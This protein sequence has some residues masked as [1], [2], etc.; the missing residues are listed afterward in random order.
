M[1]SEFPKTV[2]SLQHIYLPMT[3][4]VCFLIV[5][6][7]A[8]SSCGG[9]ANGDPAG[10]QGSIA[11]NWQFNLSTTG[12]TFSA[13]PLQGGFLL[14]KNGAVTGQIVFSI[15][16]TTGSGS[17]AVTTTCNN[18]TATVTGTM[19]GQT[20]N[21]TAVL[22]TF[23]KDGV[24]ATTQ[25]LTLSGGQ[26]SSDG[27]TIQ[28][29]KY[30]LTP[31][32][33]TSATPCGTAQDGGT[34]SAISVPALTG[35]YQGFFH[36][37]SGGA[38]GQDATVSATFTQGPNIGASSATV[39]GTLTF[40][41]PVTLLP[42]YSC[43]A[44]ASVDGTI[45]GNTVVLQI[46]GG[47]GSVIGQIGQTTATSSTNGVV[48]LNNTANGHILQ[49]L[50]VTGR[51]S[52]GYSLTTKSCS[53]GDS[54]NLCLAAGSSNACQQPISLT[55]P[56]LT[57]SPQLLGSSP[58]SQ[59]ITLTNNTSSQLTGAQI[60]LNETSS[61]VFYGS[62]VNG[63]SDFNGVRNFSEQD[64]CTQ[65]GMIS[66]GPGKSCTI[67]VNFAPQE[68]CPWLPQQVSG[69]PN[70]DGYPPVKCPLLLTAF[71]SVAVPTADTPDSDG[72]FVIPI[73]GTGLSAVVPSVGELDFGW[74][75]VGEASPPQT[76][77][78]SNQS[79]KAIYIP[80]SP[81]AQACVF[82]NNHTGFGFI[83]A[84]LARP[85]LSPP[86][87]SALANGLAVAETQNVARGN[88]VYGQPIQLENQL[89]YAPLPAPTVG[90]DCDSDP[91]ATLGGTGQPNFL[92]S[93]DTCS[94]QTLQ[95]FGHA[96]S[97]CSV[98]VTFVPQLWTGQVAVTNNLSLDDFLQ[99]N[100]AWCGDA[101][102]PA[103]PNCEIDSGRFPVE[104]K[105]NSPSPL[106]MTPGA[107]LEFGTVLKGTASAPLTLTLFNDPTDP[108]T[109][110]VTFISK[111]VTGNDY[112]ETDN[113]PVTLAANQSCEIT[114][115]F[116]PTISGPDFGQIG[117]TYTSSVQSQVSLP[118]YLRGMGQ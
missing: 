98:E 71:L 57:F 75:A 36:S 34:W 53:N 83:P 112:L 93:N 77:T 26:L 45:S 90:Y 63:G 109:A 37:T 110:A 115:I 1:K 33:G 40:Q 3:V 28:N 84:P 104:I 80:P 41:D 64:N 107:A 25:T 43:M 21:L 9:S 7:L 10:A 78:F 4:Q 47:N 46:F 62:S 54:G 42:D 22:P 32:Y 99:L 69:N 15:A 89:N 59:T 61:G 111:A 38:S 68:S 73:T 82:V 67:T 108:Q 106:R 85:P 88:V 118:I 70:I 55:P 114:V 17:Q 100:T 20:V 58:S 39:T 102:N 87:G 60:A 44:T 116:T 95:P 52:Y 96:G 29:G 12:D 13:S 113:C 101:N 19:S 92:V 30:T 94:G 103:E 18:G 23:E 49:N 72:A 79:P 35:G 6:S 91:L 51:T 50:Q 66:L 24:T 74:Q 81:S 8:L 11:G 14:Q 76:L 65:Q 31:G 5:L 2:R 16:M 86:Q 117:L 27:S 97:S 105:T 48:T 56:S